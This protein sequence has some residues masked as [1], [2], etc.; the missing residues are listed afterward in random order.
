MPASSEDSANRSFTVPHAAPTVSGA[1]QSVGPD[2]GPGTPHRRQA[3]PQS[4]AGGSVQSKLLPFLQSEPHDWLESALSADVVFSSPVRDYRGRADVAHILVTV[5]SVL[6][7]IEPQRQLVADYQVVTIITAA[8]HG[9]PMTGVLDEGYDPLGRVEH[10]TLLLRPL[11]TLLEA[12]GGIRDALER[13]PLPST[14]A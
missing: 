14:L 6:D 11:S 4:H 13:S 7:Q 3:N 10:A 12:L 1:P 9:H 5:G 8:H 2:V